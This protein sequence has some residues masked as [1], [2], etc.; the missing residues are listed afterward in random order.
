MAEAASGVEMPDLR[1]EAPTDGDAHVLTPPPA[2]ACS[3]E[4]AL[5]GSRN[6][7]ELIARKAPD[8]KAVA[9]YGGADEGAP[10]TQRT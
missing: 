9:I 6:I 3:V 7:L 10:L 8:R 1:R 2:E 4:K 5:G